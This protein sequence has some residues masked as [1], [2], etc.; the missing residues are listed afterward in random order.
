MIISECMFPYAGAGGYIFALGIYNNNKVKSLKKVIDAVHAHG[1]YFFAQFWNNG[2]TADL[3]V[4][5]KEGHKHVSLSVNYI[6][7]G[8]MFDTK[9]KAHDKGDLLH[10]LTLGK[11]GHIKKY[12]ITGAKYAFKAGADGVEVHAAGGY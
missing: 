12:Y 4:L 6:D 8:N 10:F 1:E 3:E 7:G 2:R 11:I 9:K 5:Q